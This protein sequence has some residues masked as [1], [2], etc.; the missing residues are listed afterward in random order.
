MNSNAPWW[1]GLLVGLLQYAKIKYPM[2]TA[3]IESLI[4]GLGTTWGLHVLGTLKTN[5]NGTSTNLNR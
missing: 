5:G 3:L 1:A 2:Y 4:V